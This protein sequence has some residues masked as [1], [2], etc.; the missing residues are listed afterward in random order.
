MA[1]EI[2]EQDFLQY[3]QTIQRKAREQRGVSGEMSAVKKRA[4]EAGVNMPALNFVIKIGKLDPLER[5]VILNAVFH[6]SKLLRHPEA[7]QLNFLQQL[8]PTAPPSNQD[9]QA[10]GYKAYLDGDD[11]NP[12]QYDVA[13]AA[14]QQWIAGYE[15]A[16]QD[17]Q[18]EQNTDLLTAGIKPL[19]EPEPEDE[20]DIPTFLKPKPKLKVVK[21]KPVS[22]PKRAEPEAVEPIED[23][24]PPPEDDDEEDLATRLLRR[25]RGE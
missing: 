13:S 9:Y 11:P 21:A 4:K 22:R 3:Y 12:Q 23:E 20:E 8:D 1:D 2:S 7:A 5:I 24:A 14:F 25:H 19:V 6:Y 17:M 16:R 10:Q 15:Q 18:V